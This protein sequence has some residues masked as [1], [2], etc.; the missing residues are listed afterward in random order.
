MARL[1]AAAAPRPRTAG[2][3]APRPRTPGTAEDG[4]RPRTA[5]DARREGSPVLAA[6]PAA[7]RSLKLRLLQKEAELLALDSF[8]L[9]ALR[10]DLEERETAPTGAL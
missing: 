3:D 1:R 2:E 6:L 9:L 10:T 5:D 7:N 4:R 8:K